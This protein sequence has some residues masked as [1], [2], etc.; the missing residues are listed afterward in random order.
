MSD[1]YC[2]SEPF[3][4]AAIEQNCTMSLV[5]QIF[6]GSYDADVVVPSCPYGFVPYLVKCLL[7]VYE[8]IVEI[9][10]MLQVF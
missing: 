3:S 6:N 2:N 1:S 5:I 8:D 9:L 4:C 10:L 7:E